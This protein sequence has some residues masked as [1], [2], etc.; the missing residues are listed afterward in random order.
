[1]DRIIV[2]GLAAVVTAGVHSRLPQPQQRLKARIH[3]YLPQ[4]Y[5]SIIYPEESKIGNQ[6]K[7]QQRTNFPQVQIKCYDD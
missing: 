5:L 6:A 4:K 3:L 2:F 1:M 7:A